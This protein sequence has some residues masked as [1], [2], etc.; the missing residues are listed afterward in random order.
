MVLLYIQI[1]FKHEHTLIIHNESIMALFVTETIT[2][3]FGAMNTF[4]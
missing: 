4:W 3:H 1:N 2:A